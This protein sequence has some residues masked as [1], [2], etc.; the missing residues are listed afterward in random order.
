MDDGDQEDET[1]PLGQQL[2]YEHIKL[3]K[4]NLDY[5]EGWAKLPNE[6]NWM[7]R[8]TYGEKEGPFT[9]YTIKLA[10]INRCNYF[11][12]MAWH[13][14]KSESSAIPLSDIFIVK[15]PTSGD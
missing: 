10:L 2:Y 15:G 6:A 9:M 3:T 8:N 7:I 4:D 12:D 5:Q 11:E 1:S 14:N 13:K